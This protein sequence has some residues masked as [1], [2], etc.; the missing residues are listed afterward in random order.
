MFLQVNTLQS[1][2]SFFFVYETYHSNEVKKKLTVPGTNGCKGL[3][4]TES[5]AQA[6]EYFLIFFVAFLLL[7]LILVT[8]GDE[9][10]GLLLFSLLR[11]SVTPKKE[12]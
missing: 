6:R 12:M 10:A 7:S 9:K 8:T 5:A 4:A 3:N 1:H 11:A 2:C